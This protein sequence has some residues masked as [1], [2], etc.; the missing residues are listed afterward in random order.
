MWLSTLNVAKCL[1]R[2]TQYKIIQ[3]ITKKKI[4]GYLCLTILSS[5]KFFHVGKRWKCYAGDSRGRIFCQSG[6]IHTI[7]VRSTGS[8]L[9]FWLIWGSPSTGHDVLCGGSLEQFTRVTMGRKEGG[10]PFICVCARKVAPCISLSHWFIDGN[11]SELLIMRARWTAFNAFYTI[12]AVSR[13][14]GVLNKRTCAFVVI[15]LFVQIGDID[16]IKFGIAVVSE[17]I[18]S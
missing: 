7:T 10:R 12:T 5:N 2:S 16:F 1:T 18:V 9:L 11:F 4:V 13:V 8:C 3:C 15:D 17:L 14:K 6:V